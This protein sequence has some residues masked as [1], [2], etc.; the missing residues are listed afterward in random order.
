LN[1][2]A[3]RSVSDRD[4]TAGEDNEMPEEPEATTVLDSRVGRRAAITGIGAAA[5]LAA[6]AA[7]GGKTASG[8]PGAGYGANAAPT[9]AA[10]AAGGGTPIV[11]LTDVPLG[12]SVA[13]KTA[14]G[15]PILL[16]QPTAGN[17]VAFTAICTHQGCT[18]GPAG[19]ELHCPC[20]GSVYDAFT[21][22]VKKGPAPSPLA[23]V[24]VHVAGGEVVAG[25]A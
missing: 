22:A 7:C 8:T 3:G 5:G 16:A 1:Q 24:P 10:A 19:A 18:V 20:H 21:G 6:L 12:G 13:G 14:D 17:V 25:T 15:K 23:A 9:S 2:A 4:S 11:K